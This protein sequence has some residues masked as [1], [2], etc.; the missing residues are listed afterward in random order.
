MSD[1]D[2]PAPSTHDHGVVLEHIKVRY[3]W[4]ETGWADRNEDGT[5][6]ISNIPA[7]CDDLMWGDVV[8]IDDKLDES[9]VPR[10]LSVVS[11]Q[12]PLRS[13]VHYEPVTRDAWV[14]VSR[15]IRD[16]DSGWT[17]GYRPGVGA[18]VHH[19]A[20]TGPVLRGLLADTGVEAHLVLTERARVRGGWL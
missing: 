1:G 6:T 4:R 8:L 18:V 5:I 16:S 10:V 19:E 12:Y 9:G 13:E 11:R 3:G 15:A 17:E 2:D 7:T 20:L 14:A